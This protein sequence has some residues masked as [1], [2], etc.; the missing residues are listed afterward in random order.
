MY[1]HHHLFHF[2][3]NGFT[4]Y[5]DTVQRKIKRKW[6]GV[7]KKK[8][9]H[10]VTRSSFVEEKKQILNKKW[11][12]LKPFFLRAKLYVT[13]V[14]F[15]ICS[16]VVCATSDAKVGGESKR[17]G[18]RGP[19]LV[20]PK[21]VCQKCNSEGSLRRRAEIGQTVMEGN[22]PNV[23]VPFSSVVFFQTRPGVGP[24]SLYL[25]HLSVVEDRLCPFSESM[26]TGSLCLLAK[27]DTV[28]SSQAS[29]Q[30]EVGEVFH[31]RPNWKRCFIDKAIP[32]YQFFTSRNMHIC[33]RRLKNSATSS[34][35]FVFVFC[36]SSGSC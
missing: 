23:R 32:C 21:N 29:A 33:E 7:S 8:I 12:A 35:R 2:T 28:F 15:I 1:S 13:G 27:S 22:E 30:L 5:F 11:S 18:R 16:D 26:E 20:L 19:A 4:I 36:W 17:V 9:E 10:R 24:L 3:T 14:F 6:V 25:S 31:L 34:Y